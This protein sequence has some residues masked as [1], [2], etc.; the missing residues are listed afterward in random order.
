MGKLIVKAVAHLTPLP[1]SDCFMPL[2]LPPTHMQRHSTISLTQCHLTP[3]PSTERLMLLLS[4]S[5]PFS[6]TMHAAATV[7]LLPMLVLA[8]TMLSYLVGRSP[9]R[10]RASP[11]SA[12]WRAEEGQRRGRKKNDNEIT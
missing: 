8:A 4:P 3:L 9:E 11:G 6:P 2:W 12:T 7:V 10:W 5:C 1:T